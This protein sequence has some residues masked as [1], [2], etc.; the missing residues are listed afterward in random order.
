MI[1]H[2]KEVITTLSKRHSV[3]S[4]FLGFILGVGFT[5]GAYFGLK[6]YAPNL[7]SNFLTGKKGPDDGTKRGVG[8]DS[9]LVKGMV[10]EI[11]A[12]DQG[13][14]IVEELFRSESKKTLESFFQEA[15]KS[16]EFR[17]T[18]GEALESFLATPQGKEL[19]KKIAREVVIP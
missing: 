13:K 6:D 15:T 4:F 18:L 9:T 3:L 2:E 10:Q 14:A 11:L 17:K 19:V 16:P 7:M 8:V 5:F 1:R 12:S